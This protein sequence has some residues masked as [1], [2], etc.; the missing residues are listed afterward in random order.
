MN[1]LEARPPT[2]FV[3]QNNSLAQQTERL[4]KTYS[5]PYPPE[6]F[7]TYKRL[8]S[9]RN[10]PEVAQQFSETE[11]EVYLKTRF[12]EDELTIMLLNE[13][14]DRQH[15]SAQFVDTSDT[16]FHIDLELAE[17][18]LSKRFRIGEF[19]DLPEWFR[20]PAVCLHRWSNTKP[21]DATTPFGTLPTF[22]IDS[23]GRI[24]QFRNIYFLNQ[25]GQGLKREEILCVSEPDQPLEKALVSWGLDY[26]NTPHLDMP[27]S[28]E[29]SRLTP[30][31][32]KDYEQL[33]LSIEAIQSGKFKPIA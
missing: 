24:Y 12:T 8:V 32:A 25:F 14:A 18:S 11:A 20:C 29:L 16:D 13:Y 22:V 10:S 27:L 19:G 21:P 26:A 7:E 15:S 2:E 30:L 4:I 5:K 17:E 33:T 3:S 9:C 23:L 28:E 31:T 6:F 1:S